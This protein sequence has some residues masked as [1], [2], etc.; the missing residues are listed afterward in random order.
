MPSITAIE[1]SARRFAR[2]IQEAGFTVDV[3]VF[4]C[5]PGGEQH[6]GPSYTELEVSREEDAEGEGF[7]YETLRFY[8]GDYAVGGGSEFSAATWGEMKTEALEYL[9]RCGVE[10]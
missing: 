2:K 9:D 4:K 10:V 1:K 6:Y 5:G 3:D 8:A 7:V